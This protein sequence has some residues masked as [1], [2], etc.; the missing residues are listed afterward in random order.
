ML[1]YRLVK[2][3]EKL[4]VSVASTVEA[5]WARLVVA[6]LIQ[7]TIAAPAWLMAQ[8]DHNDIRNSNINL[9]CG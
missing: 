4:S 6:S 8:G 2:A 3:S 1:T 9:E 7:T 5:R